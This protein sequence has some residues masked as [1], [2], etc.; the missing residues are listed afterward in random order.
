MKKCK[1]NVYLEKYVLRTPVSIDSGCNFLH[2]KLVIY[3][4]TDDT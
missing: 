3:Y 1:K 4:N 2:S